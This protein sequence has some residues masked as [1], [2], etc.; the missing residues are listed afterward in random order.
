MKNIE[1]SIEFGEKKAIYEKE[2]AWEITELGYLLQ[3][4]QLYMLRRNI[5]IIM[6]MVFYRISTLIRISILTSS[7]HNFARESD[8]HTLY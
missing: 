6:I 4:F 5:F 2:T 8:L 7:T 1:V 3:K